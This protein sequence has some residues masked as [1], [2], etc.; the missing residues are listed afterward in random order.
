V[1]APAQ[2]PLRVAL[3]LD[4]ARASGWGV[5]P[6]RGRVIHHGVARTHWQRLEVAELAVQLAG[7]DPRRVFVMFEQH[8]HM[9]L[10]RLGRNDFT[11]KRSGDRAFAVERG[12]K[13][14]HGIGKAYGRWEAVLDHVRIPESMRAEVQPSVW[15]RAIHGVTSGDQIKQAAVDWAMRELGEPLQT[16]DEAEGICIT[17]FAALSGLAKLDGERIH[18]RAV[19]QAKKQAASQGALAFDPALLEQMG[20]GA[21]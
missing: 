8:D 21:K 7:G 4:Q 19:N 5:A 2:K 17:T 1:K 16:D 11:T 9:Q 12:P 15:R 18:N 20:K 14:I 10:D 6:E 13:Q 3:G